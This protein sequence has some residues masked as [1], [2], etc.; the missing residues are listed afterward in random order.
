M[1]HTFGMVVSLVLNGKGTT[2]PTAFT[3]SHMITDSKIPSIAQP[4]EA[5]P[6][7]SRRP[8][9]PDRAVRPGD[10]FVTVADWLT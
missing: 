1:V 7:L 3:S 9:L 5:A 4:A 2:L 8:A 10:G 6:R